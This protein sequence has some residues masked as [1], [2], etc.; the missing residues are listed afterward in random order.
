[1]SIVASANAALHERILA[2][3]DAGLARL[4]DLDASAWRASPLG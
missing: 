1:M 3:L 4:A 2:E